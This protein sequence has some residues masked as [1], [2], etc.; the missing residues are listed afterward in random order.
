MIQRVL[1]NLV[2]ILTHILYYVSNFINIVIFVFLVMS[3]IYL[4]DLKSSLNVIS[5]S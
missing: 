1:W 2:S 3:V 5:I 4:T